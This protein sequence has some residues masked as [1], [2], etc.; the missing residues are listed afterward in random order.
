MT[1]C[2]RGNAEVWEKQCGRGKEREFLGEA[3]RE[4]WSDRV[5]DGR[6]I[7]KLPGGEKQLQQHSVYRR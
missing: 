3:S 7:M 6:E 5:L 1:V 4:C 2:G